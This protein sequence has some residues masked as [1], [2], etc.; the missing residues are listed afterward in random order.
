MTAEGERDCL[1]L[2]VDW[3]L[4][5]PPVFLNVCIILPSFAVATLLCLKLGE[6]CDDS[7]YF[8][9]TTEAQGNRCREEYESVAFAIFWPGNQAIFCP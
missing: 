6:L 3:L 4:V 2:D 9:L 1:Q 8:P 7:L 5:V